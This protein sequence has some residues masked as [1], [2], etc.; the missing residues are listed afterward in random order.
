MTRKQALCVPFALDGIQT[1]EFAII[2]EAYKEN[3]DSAIHTS[4][5]ITFG[6]KD[7]DSNKLMC[8]VDFALSQTDIPFIK[9]KV[10]CYFEV[11]EK[12]WENAYDSGSNSLIF[13]KEF[14]DHLVVLTLGT[15]R[16]VL[17]AKTESTPYNKYFVPTIN[18]AEQNTDDLKIQLD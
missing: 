5:G 10:A 12:C 6:V 4:L 9:I 13:P 8:L 14:A 7:K 2:K 1:I 16:G 17:H 3:V 18:I 11:D 15:L